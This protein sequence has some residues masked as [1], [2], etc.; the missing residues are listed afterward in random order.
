MTDLQINT[1][2]WIEIHCEKCGSTSHYDPAFYKEGVTTCFGCMPCDT[3]EEFD[4]K[5]REGIIK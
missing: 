5:V 3:P 1:T 4:R 2:G